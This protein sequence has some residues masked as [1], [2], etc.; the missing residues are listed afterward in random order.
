MPVYVPGY[1]HDI[2]VSYAT[3]D[4][5]AIAGD[6]TR[7]V[8]NLIRLLKIRLAQK[9]GRLDAYSLWMDPQR[10]D[11]FL[12]TEA[13][14]RL[15]RTATLL[16][17]LSPGYLASTA[18]LKE[19]EQ[20]LIYV[21]K[22]SARL[23]KIEYQPTGVSLPA[24]EGILGYR[25]WKQDVTDRPRSLG[26]PKPNPEDSDEYYDQVDNLV[27]DL[28]NQLIYLKEQIEQTGF[29]DPL[30]KDPPKAQIFL[31]E[32]SDDLVLQREELKR[33]LELQGITTLP[34]APYFFPHD[35]VA[36]LHAIDT[37]LQA[38]DIFVQLLSQSL[39]QRPVG[40]STPQL[41]YD[42]AVLLNKAIL[43]WRNR[44]LDIDTITD[45]THHTLLTQSTVIATGMVEFQDYLVKTLDKLTKVSTENMRSGELVF[46]N[47][48]PH[49]MSLA[50][51]V[52]DILM[53]QGLGYSL[54]M[55]I[56][57]Q[58]LPD[59]IREDLEKN[60]QLCDAVI[61][62]YSDNNLGWVRYQLLQC[63]RARSKR[64]EPYKVIAVCDQQ[65]S[66][67]PPVNIQLPD[68][69]I[70]ACLLPYPKHC[71]AGFM[72]ILRP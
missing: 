58:T 70:L 3:V 18:C 17:I 19:L 26:S 46:I 41:Q 44:D 50:Q 5:L 48:E 22:T 63:H 51:E 60:L 11:T 34:T 6:D 2:Y 39:P 64:K 66:D 31:A 8:N 62:L 33:N 40:M 71:A 72:Q 55:T 65:Q 43:Q 10:T 13:I 12:A 30:P 53:T 45:N 27:I 61:V 42:R 32:V 21:G 14:A 9:L 57:E 47:A 23:F 67:K 52:A 38:S 68:L 37:D 54:P 1:Q 16:I 35:E 15:Q 24:L 59:V 69:H 4:N 56:S 7:W 49:D 28:A 36:L 29:E 25:F 20:F